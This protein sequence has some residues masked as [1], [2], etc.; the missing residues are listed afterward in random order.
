[1]VLPQF[2]T[3]GPSG[4]YTGQGTAHELGPRSHNYSLVSPFIF[5]AVLFIFFYVN[6]FI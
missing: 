4:S 3:T 2:H 6:T 5:D 1:M